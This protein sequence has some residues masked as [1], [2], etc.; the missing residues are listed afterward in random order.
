MRSILNKMMSRRSTLVELMVVVAIIGILA[1]VAIPNYQKYQARARQSESKVALAAAFTAEK[2]FAAEQNTFTGCLQNAGYAPDNYLQATGR[3]YYT[4]GFT[5]A[6]A[7]GATCGLSG[8]VACNFYSYNANTG[9]PGATCT[10][11]GA[12]TANDNTMFTANV[13]ASAGAA[14]TT[15][16]SGGTLTRSTFVIFADGQISTTV[17]AN[18]TWTI[19]DQKVLTNVT[20][21]I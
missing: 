13:F 3:R 5:S 19:D 2:G 9:A 7:T 4:L 14:A 1:A 10:G 20:N 15:S 18:D 11:A 12:Q 21:N 6:V 8:G 16:V 17:S